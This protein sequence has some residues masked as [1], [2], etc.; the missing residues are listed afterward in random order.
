MVAKSW[1][2]STRGAR[3]LIDGGA[4]VAECP[5][6]I[7]DFG[8][9]ARGPHLGGGAGELPQAVVEAKPYFRL[10]KVAASEYVQDCLGFA[11]HPSQND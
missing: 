1:S 2:L 9:F 8:L 5:Q 7:Q 10:G 11:A 3:Q 4:F 6:R